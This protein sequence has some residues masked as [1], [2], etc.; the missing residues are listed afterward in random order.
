MRITAP[1]LPLPAALHGLPRPVLRAF[2]PPRRVPVLVIG[3]S[4]TNAVFAE[5]RE[6][7]DASFGVLNM[8]QELGAARSLT[9]PFLAW[10]APEVVVS[11]MGSV[12]YHLISLVEQR[13]PFDF[14]FPGAPPPL[15]QRRLVPCEEIRAELASRLS[16]SIDKTLLLHRTYDRPTA[17]VQ[18]PP[19]SEDEEHNRRALERKRAEL[20]PGGLAVAPFSVRLKCYRLQSQILAERFAAEGITAIDPPA[21][22]ID[23]AGGLAA[24]YR[25]D[26]PVHGNRDYGRLVLEQLRAFHEASR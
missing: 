23:E 17:F 13:N 11:M 6:A 22:A 5:L 7:R 20:P 25:M 4:H 8:S 15:P 10:F 3:A 19:P 16:S 18:P 14:E 12:A 9:R 26:D 1:A 21:A 24:P 2:L